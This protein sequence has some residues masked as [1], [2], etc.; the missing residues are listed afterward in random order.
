MDSFD[1]YVFIFLT[2]FNHISLVV[3]A[4][5]A[6]K[7]KAQSLFRKLIILKC[8]LRLLNDVYCSNSLSHSKS[9]ASLIDVFS[10]DRAYSLLSFFARIARVCSLE[11]LILTSQVPE[12]WYK[13]PEKKEGDGNK[14]GVEGADSA[15]AKNTKFICTL[16]EDIPMDISSFFR[17]ILKTICHRRVLSEGSRKISQVMIDQLARDAMES[18]NWSRG[19]QSKHSFDFLSLALTHLRGLICEERGSGSLFQAYIAFSICQTSKFTPLFDLAVELVGEKLPALV[20]LKNGND[21]SKKEQAEKS[22]NQLNA[23]VD[24]IADLCQCLVS[25]RYHQESPHTA[26]LFARLKDSGALSFDPVAFLIQMRLEILPPFVQLLLSPNLSKFSVYAINRVVGT[27]LLVLKR[28]GEQSSAAT[29]AAPAPTTGL[30]FSIAALSQQIFGGRPVSSGLPV[31]AA[32]TAPAPPRADPAKVDILADMGFPRPAAEIALSRCG[33]NVSRAADYLLTHPEVLSQVPEPAPPAA[34]T[35][36]GPDAPPASDGAG[37]SSAPATTTEEVAESSASALGPSNPTADAIPRDAAPMEQDAEESSNFV[38]EEPPVDPEVT[39]QSTGGGGEDKGKDVDKSAEIKE[40]NLADLTELRASKSSLIYD[41]VISLLTELESVTLVFGLKELL[42][43]DSMK[44]PSIAARIIASV[45]EYHDLLLSGV[46]ESDAAALKRIQTSLY[47]HYHMLALIVSDSKT[48]KTIEIQRSVLSSDEFRSLSP[49][50]LLSRVQDFQLWL[51]PLLL[52]LESYMSFC[53]EPTDVPLRADPS[54]FDKAPDVKAEK[55]SMET[56]ITMISDLIRIV[57]IQSL[58]TNSLHVLL[59]LIARLTLKWPVALSFVENGGFQALFK[60]EKYAAF[61]THQSIIMIIARHCLEEPQLLQGLMKEE[62]KKFLKH[63]RARS[64]D[65]AFLIKSCGHIIV[66]STDDFVS[67]IGS[68]CKLNSYSA[69]PSLRSIQISLQECALDEPAPSSSTAAPS[70]SLITK[71]SDPTKTPS[72]TPYKFSSN[73]KLEEM[74]DV[75]KVVQFLTGQLISLKHK[76]PSLSKYNTQCFL[77]QSLCE[78]FVSFPKTKVDFIKSSMRKSTKQTPKANSSKNIILGYLLHEVV[79]VDLMLDDATVIAKDE[80]DHHIESAWACRFLTALCYFREGYLDNPLPNELQAIRVFVI[81]ALLKA[82]KDAIS[83]EEGLAFEIR[84]GKTV[85]LANLCHDLLTP[86]LVVTPYEATHLEAHSLAVAKLMIEKGFVSVFT[87]AL[88]SLDV[89][90]PSCSMV[91]FSFLQPLDSLASAAIKIGKTVDSSLSISSTSKSGAKKIPSLF[92]NALQD[93]E[94]EGA[95]HIGQ[96]PHE[97]SDMFRNSALGMLEPS[98]QD[99]HDDSED[100]DVSDEEDEFD[101]FDE[102]DEEDMD[103]DMDEVCYSFLLFFLIYGRF[104]CRILTRMTTW[105]SWFL[106]RIMGVASMKMTGNHLLMMKLLSKMY[107]LEIRFWKRT[108][109]TWM[110]YLVKMTLMAI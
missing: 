72:G 68:V 96:T 33:N 106:S 45:V 109:M 107:L 61:P 104:P 34:S 1:W 108:M 6:E 23:V 46:Y 67:A 74:A 101:E 17:G 47:L 56:R 92:D 52:V 105:K 3:S 82:L 48:A 63:P 14:K 22:I 100:S 58:D 5:D 44:I 15:A 62:L 7:E 60:Y 75:S 94:D 71:D 66:R 78:L 9:I 59:R 55:I 69:T 80:L 54:L 26:T 90:H 20:V 73:P 102:M 98:L 89:N 53:D 86:K 42:C 83:Q 84:H 32:A 110:K 81:D 65:L 103:D 27:I 41:R 95:S 18:L 77:L 79:P 11:W 21:S 49:L 93:L 10:P 4:D 8:F 38:V 43:L 29:R 99:H 39:G 76:E 24:I 16:L 85:S 64:V 12:G 51:A 30:P 2:F 13:K 31:S 37:T 36:S 40:K 28:D 70:L 88:A 87:S 57:N 91:V 19:I 50:G 97:I 35:S 25:D